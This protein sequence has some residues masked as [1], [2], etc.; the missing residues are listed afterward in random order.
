[1]TSELVFDAGGRARPLIVVR[2]HNA[3]GLRL[4]IDPRDASVRL[5]MPARSSLRRAVKWVGEQRPWIEAELKKLPRGA[6]IVPGM[7]FTFAGKPVQLEWQPDGPRTPR[8]VGNRI[9]IGGPIDF[10]PARLLRFLRA[11]ARRILEQETREL[12]ARHG[13]GIARVGV[14]DT[15][16]RWGSCSTSGDIRYSWRLILAP[17]FVR[18]ATVAHEVAHRVHMDHSPAFHALVKT[19]HG[20]DPGPARQ[21]LRDHGTALHIFGSAG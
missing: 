9:A 8:L 7:A 5:T 18:T 4:R 20:A 1:M 15:R 12:A 21:W 16:S 11:E 14:G 17:D 3:K 19:F 6:P 13:I 2:S 10:L